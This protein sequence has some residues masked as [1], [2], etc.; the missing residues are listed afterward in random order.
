MSVEQDKDRPAE[1]QIIVGD[2]VGGDQ[3]TGDK[4]GGDK[5]TTGDIGG[6]YNAVGPGAQ[7]NIFHAAPSTPE[8]P[9]LPFEP[10]IILI[11]AGPFIMGADD[12]PLAAPR[13][14]VELPDYGIGRYPVTNE[15]FAEFIR[16]T[17]RIA[18]RDL[19]WEGNQPPRDKLGHPVTGVTWLEARAYCDWLAALT[20]RPYS[21]PSEAEWEKA[22]RGTDGR[23]FPWGN[24]WADGRCHTDLESVAAVD[25]YPAQ[26]SYDCY[27]MVGNTR[28]WTTTLWGDAPREPDELYKYP[29]AA[30]GRR[31]NLHAPAT[32]RRVFRGGRG[33]GAAA[34]YCSKRGA[35]LPDQSGP[36][37]NRLGFRV[38]LHSANGRNE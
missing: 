22:A 3:V 31:D 26:S 29:W 4:V 14:T 23:L 17:N 13:H 11:P 37:R 35:L 5:I 34:Y 8:K 10:K 25:A 15:Q 1:Q 27:D 16:Q 30:D 7:V 32:T 18:S 28:E 6:S 20:E 21:L 19:L 33:E 24:E 12:D 2:R 36:R 38:V 9:R